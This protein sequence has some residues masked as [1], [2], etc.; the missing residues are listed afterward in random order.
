M[1]ERLPI[2]ETVCNSLLSKCYRRKD[3]AGISGAK[4]RVKS[5]L[6]AIQRILMS[7]LVYR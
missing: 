6:H 7:T 5:S 1:E 4:Y 2:K 3:S